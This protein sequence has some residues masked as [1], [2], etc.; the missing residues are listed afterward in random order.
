MRAQEGYCERLCLALERLAAASAVACGLL[1]RSISIVLNN[2][3]QP[4]VRDYHVM[5]PVSSRGV[6]GL[7]EGGMERCINSEHNTSGCTLFY[8]KMRSL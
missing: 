4:L 8:I 6:A 2:H 1:G 5:I 3:I 7:A